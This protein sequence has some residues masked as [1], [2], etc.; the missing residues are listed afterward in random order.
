ML[1]D[2]AQ[3]HF[4]EPDDMSMLVEMALALVSRVKRPIAWIH[5]PVP[6]G[7]N[8]QTY[9]YFRA[10]PHLRISQIKPHI[11]AAA[12]AVRVLTKHGEKE[13]PEP[14]SFSCY[15]KIKAGLAFFC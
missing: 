11:G 10:E 6:K 7:R 12:F 5:M 3:R 14:S 1:G 8:D 9:V 2:F 4:V 15:S 13:D